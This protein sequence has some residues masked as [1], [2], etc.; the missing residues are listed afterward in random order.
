MNTDEKKQL[1]IKPINKIYRDIKRYKAILRKLNKRKPH[2][3]KKPKYKYI[4]LRHSKTNKSLTNT[5]LNLRWFE[6]EQ[7]SFNWSTDRKIK[8]LLNVNYKGLTADSI[9]SIMLSIE[10]NINPVKL[11]NSIEREVNTIQLYYCYTNNSNENQYV[12]KP[13]YRI[14]APRNYK[15]RMYF[16]NVL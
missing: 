14:K 7:Y 1:L 9:K 2:I 3:N 15:K 13:K 4:S 11:M 10:P 16:K 12:L 6:L 8:Y 5:K